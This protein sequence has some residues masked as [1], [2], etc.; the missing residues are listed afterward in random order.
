MLQKYCYVEAKL[1]SINKI[2]PNVALIRSE[3]ENFRD[4]IEKT[5]R[6]AET[7]SAKVRK[8]DLARVR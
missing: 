2:L 7:V 6:L 8:L 3:G 1:Q 5:N 4:T